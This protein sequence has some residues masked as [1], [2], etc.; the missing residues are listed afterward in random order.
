M[1][2][3]VL[4]F[5]TACRLGFDES[6]L[7]GRDANL[8][9]PDGS[10]RCPS[11]RGPAMSLVADGFCIDNTEVTKAQYEEF[12]AASVPVDN[13]GRCTFNQTYS[14]KEYVD[15]ATTDP[16]QAVAG[17]DWCDARDFCAWAGKRLCGKIGGGSLAFSDHAAPNAQWYRACSQ[18]GL[19]RRFSYGTTSDDTAHSG[20]CHLDNSNNAPGQQAVVGSYPQCVLVGTNV[21]D[22]LG[23]IQE[24]TDACET[25]AAADGDD[26]CKVVGGVWYF[27]SSYSDC[28]FFDPSGSAGVPRDTAEKH[29]GFRCCAD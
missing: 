21:Y 4:L 15:I 13:S 19:M 6:P 1:R 20:W 9:S 27:G 3:L 29:T 11:G 18:G 25:T 24:W 14:I 23:N 2:V 28:D 17:V 22:L 7:D 16:E 8:A 26:L 5:V 10:E 12:L